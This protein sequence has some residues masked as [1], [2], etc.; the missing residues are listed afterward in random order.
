MV[1]QFCT[2]NGV[3]ENVFCIEKKNACDSHISGAGVVYDSTGHFRHIVSSSRDDEYRCQLGI[4]FQFLGRY[5]HRQ[6][7]SRQT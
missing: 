2:E 4:E 1:I 5:S 6:R 3:S 7:F